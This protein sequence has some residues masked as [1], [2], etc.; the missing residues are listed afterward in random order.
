TPRLGAAEE[1]ESDQGAAIGSASETNSAPPDGLEMPGAAA[2][3]ATGETGDS[4]SGSSSIS[5]GDSSSSGSM[6]SASGDGGGGGDSS[7]G[8][9]QRVAILGTSLQVLVDHSVM[10]VFGGGGRARVTSRFYPAGEDVA[11]GV[12]AYARFSLRQAPGPAT[13]TAV[14][15]PSLPEPRQRAMV[16]FQSAVYRLEDGI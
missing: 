13:A 9:P 12:Q 16:G 15:P 14:L 8:S 10:E 7:G 6:V 5:F 1:S 11:W 4:S 2:A 3:A